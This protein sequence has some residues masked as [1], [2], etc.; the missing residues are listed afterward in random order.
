M[1]ECPIFG[2]VLGVFLYSKISFEDWF[3]GYIQKLHH[4]HLYI[5]KKIW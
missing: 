1:L 2:M 4:Y 3:I 5:H